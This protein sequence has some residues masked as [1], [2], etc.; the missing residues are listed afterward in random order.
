MIDFQLNW[1]HGTQGIYWNIGDQTVTWGQ[2]GSYSIPCVLEKPVRLIVIT[3]HGSNEN[4]SHRY[5]QFYENDTN[6]ICMYRLFTSFY[7]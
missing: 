3:G 7:P 5:I 6:R 4:G 1:S 2:K